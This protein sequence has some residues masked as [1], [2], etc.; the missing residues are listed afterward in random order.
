MHEMQTGL[1]VKV[2]AA[3][4]ELSGVGQTAAWAAA[5]VAYCVMTVCRVEKTTPIAQ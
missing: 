3:V 4:R 1:H 5:E 2:N